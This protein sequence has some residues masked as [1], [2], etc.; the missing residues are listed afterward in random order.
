MTQIILFLALI[1]CIGMAQIVWQQLFLGNWHLVESAFFPIGLWWQFRQ[2][3]NN[4]QVYFTKG[5]G[6][7][8][9]SQSYK[10]RNT[11]FF[12]L[13]F[14]VTNQVTS[15]YLLNSINLPKDELFFN[16]FFYSWGYLNLFEYL[17]ILS[18][19]CIYIYI[20]ISVVEPEF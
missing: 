9:Y 15:L 13:G 18:S 6:W 16:N 8:K 7:S 3:R 12:A 2:H 20:Y 17:T 10:G 5:S 4:Q 19:V 14:N 1:Y 11:Q